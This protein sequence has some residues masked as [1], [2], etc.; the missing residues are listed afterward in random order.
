VLHSFTNECEPEGGLVFD[1]VGNL[2]GTTFAGGMFGGGAAFQLAASPGGTWTYSPI[3]EFD[4]G[5]EDGA[6]PVGAMAFDS[7]GNLYGATNAGGTFSAGT[8]FELTLDSGTWTENIVHD[9][10]GGS[11]GAS[12]AGDLVL[13]SSG[14]IFGATTFGG[15]GTSFGSIFRLQPGQGG[16]WTETVFGMGHGPRGESP[17]GALLLDGRGHIYGTT[18]DGGRTKNGVYGHGVVFRL[19]MGH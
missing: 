17:H 14:N 4:P 2:Y 3:Y 19:N 12:P 11:D 6:G 5:I 16:T 13:D 18:L 10:A 9:F 8:V 15:G 7:L 1:D